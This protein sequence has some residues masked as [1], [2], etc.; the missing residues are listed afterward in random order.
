M[1]GSSIYNAFWGK[2]P[3][4]HEYRDPGPDDLR[5]PCPFL[6]ALANHVR[7][8]TFYSIRSFRSSS[9]SSAFFF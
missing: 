7:V 5:S 1:G 6:N 4:N 8:F 9:S 2:D 3:Y